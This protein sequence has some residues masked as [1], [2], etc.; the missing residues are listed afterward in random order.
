[1]SRGALLVGFVLL[2]ACDSAAQLALKSA[3]TGALPLQFGVAWLS[4]LLHQRALYGAI[5]GFVAGFLVWMALL[6]HAPIGPA[7]AASNLDIVAVL[8]A[9]SWWLGE[10]VGA[11][12]I[13][14]AALIV[15]GVGC[16]AWAS[17]KTVRD[18][19]G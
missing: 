18:P 6:R 4:R 7:F 13:V 2:V 17:G 16:L 1:M 10:H 11:W 14:G 3:S 8:V 5:L 15:A 9:S 12:Q 19:P